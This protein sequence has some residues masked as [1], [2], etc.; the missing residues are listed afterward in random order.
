[1]TLFFILMAPF[2]AS[3]LS[4]VTASTVSALGTIGIISTSIQLICSIAIAVSVSNA[5]PV[6]A[7]Y[8]GVDHLGAI[9]LVLLAFGGLI[10][11]IYARGYTAAEMTKGVIGFNRAK[12]LY[13]QLHLFLLAMSLAIVTT[14]PILTW[15]AIEAT[16]LTTAFL[17]SYYDKPSAMEAA[18]KYLILNSVGLLFAF[19][20]TLLY[21]TPSLHGASGPE[22]WQGLVTQAGNYNPFIVKMAFLFALVGYGTKAGFAPMH[23]WLPDAHS[24]A[25]SPISSLLSGVLLNI[26]LLAILRAKSITDATVGPAYTSELLI[27][28]GLLS[29]II[30]AS[31]ILVQKNYKRL[32]AYSSIENM[33]V[34]ALGFGIGGSASYAAVLHMI[35]HSLTKSLLFLSAGTILIKY[36]STK[37]EEIKGV[38]HA[39]PVTGPLFF[40]GIL[41][42]IGMPP[43]GIF[44]TEFSILISGIQQYPAV[45]I[46]ALCALILAGIG[47]MRHITAM[48]FHEPT[49][50]VPQGEISPWMTVPLC[51]LAVIIMIISIILPQPIQT[52]ITLAAKIL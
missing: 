9:I 23:T 31:I 46:I 52:F 6:T 17:I 10:S 49:H 29:L 35:Y 2:I 12:K 32:L 19:F 7:P 14:N 15:I 34:I 3:I 37:I 21:L 13:A 42:L 16:T 45:T 39:L 30:S 25:P 41:T 48:E 20:G 8:L 33:G 22:T 47:F 50:P 5:I 43:M 24:K 1:M 38:L 18:W 26:P 51:A 44:F 27:A 40:F 11:S 36:G 28:F 4:F